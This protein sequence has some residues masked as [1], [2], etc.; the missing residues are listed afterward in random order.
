M[1]SQFEK[2]LCDTIEICLN[3][4]DFEEIEDTICMF[5]YRYKIM[6]ASKT[7]EDVI[8]TIFNSIY[9]NR[10]PSIIAKFRDLIDEYD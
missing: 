10:V 8:G 2:E 9:N 3:L 1:N 4:D 7:F 6:P 5:L